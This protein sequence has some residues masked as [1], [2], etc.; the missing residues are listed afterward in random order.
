MSVRCRERALI[1]LAATEKVSDQV[2]AQ[3]LGTTR[4]RVARWRKRFEA[5]GIEALKKDRPRGGRPP[6]ID[7]A[8][9]KQIVR[10]TTQSTPRLEYARPSGLGSAT[11]RCCVYGTLMA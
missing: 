3:R 5:G 8:K 9:I 10:L 4:H 7:A 1:V 6:S 2:L 11:P